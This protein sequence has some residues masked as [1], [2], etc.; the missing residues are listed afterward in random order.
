VPESESLTHGIRV[1]VESFYVPERSRPAE[2]QWFF[3]YTIRVSNERSDT[4]RLLSRH[5]HITDANGEVQQ[6]RGDGVIG[7]QPVLQP[8]E[9][10]EY[11][12]ACPLH[13]AFGT[14]HGTYT[15]ADEDSARFEVRIAPFALSE[16]HS[17]N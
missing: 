15:M 4:V 9:A 7:Q 17:I 6:V 12:S 11:T 3:G 5:W 1:Q 14:M 16:P 13:T 10:F 2:G 8:G